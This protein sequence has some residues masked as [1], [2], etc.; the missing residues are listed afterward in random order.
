M[1][2]I[3]F[4]LDLLFFNVRHMLC[5]STF[6][7]TVGHKSCDRPNKLKKKIEITQVN[8]YNLKKKR[9]CIRSYFAHPA[10]IPYCVLLSLPLS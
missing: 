8:I 9:L 4:A 10:L 2:F 6:Y 5:K 1:S 3:I 7:I